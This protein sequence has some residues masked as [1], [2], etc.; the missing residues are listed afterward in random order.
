MA[1]KEYQLQAWLNAGRKPVMTVSFIEAVCMLF[2]DC[3]IGDYLKEGE[4]LFDKRATQALQ[5]L[6]AAVSAINDDRRQ[7]EIINDPLMD[8]VREKAAR[9]LFLIN[10]ST[11]EGSTVDIAVPGQSEPNP[12]IGLG[13]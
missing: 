12:K 3:V 11:Y 7:D 9:A 8:V 13:S 5:E 10:V 6:D 1:D 2:D 4:I